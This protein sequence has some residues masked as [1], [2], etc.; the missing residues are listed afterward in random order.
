MMYTKKSLS[1]FA[2]GQGGNRCS[3]VRFLS[4]GRTVATDGYVLLE[5]RDGS[6]LADRGIVPFTLPADAVKALAKLPA[7]KGPGKGAFALDVDETNKNGKA[8]FSAGDATLATEKNTLGFP[9]YESI[10]NSLQKPAMLS[11][12]LGVPVLES[13]IKA[14]KSIGSD[15]IRLDFQADDKASEC[16]GSAIKVTIEST[17]GDVLNGAAMPMRF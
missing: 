6:K 1:V 11:V 8:F 7:S 2:A 10:M 5:Y 17:D 14:A 15:K 4:D 12:A 13:L 16:Y 3:G 9:Q